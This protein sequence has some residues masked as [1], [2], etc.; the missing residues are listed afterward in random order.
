MIKGNFEELNLEIDEERSV[1][2]ITINR[3][4]KKNCMSRKFHKEIDSALTMIE[5][6][7]EIKVLV[8]TGVGDS[9]CG[10]MDLEGCFL[11]PFM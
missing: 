8:L 11:G 1:A 3:P 5:D 4:Q 7:G 6:A 2:R 10:G 9:F